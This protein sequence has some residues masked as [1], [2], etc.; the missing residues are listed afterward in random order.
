MKEKLINLI[1]VKSI[2]T[3]VLT[4]VFGAMTLNKMIDSEKFFIVYQ[5]IIVFYFGT[6][7]GKKQNEDKGEK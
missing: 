1:D 3:I 7:V 6:Q 4:V 5:M 2:I